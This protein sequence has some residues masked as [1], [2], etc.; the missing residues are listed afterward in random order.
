VDVLLHGR[1]V[2]TSVA[3]IG[4]GG[5]GF[6]V[7]EF[8]SHDD[9]HA[10]ASLDIPAFMRE[11]GID[12]TLEARGGL[13]AAAELRSSR[14]IW[15]LQRKPTPAGRDLGKTTGWVHRL[16]L[17]RRGVRM[18]SGVAYERIDDAGLTIRQGG[19]ARLL[20]V[21]NV[22]VC[23]GQEPRR[24]L[25]DGLAR[26]GIK[27]HLIGGSLHAAELDAKRAIDEGSRLA[28]AL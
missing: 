13:T 20:A 22:V 17:K 8:L 14:E 7:A 18:L 9:A 24:E 15:L 23:A 28:A 26:A 3:I 25:V 21:D 12:M 10:S 19:E 2:G 5:I 4:A 11:W 27:P 6:D 16:A 1:P